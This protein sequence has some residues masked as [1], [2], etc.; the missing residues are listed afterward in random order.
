MII[1]FVRHGE[2]HRPAGTSH[3]GAK[4]IGLSDFGK[5]RVKSLAKKL[6]KLEIEGV[7]SSTLFRAVETATPLSSYC[8]VPLTYDNRL[9]EHTVSRNQTDRGQIREL[10]QKVRMDH[11]FVPPDGESF[12][13]TVSR[14]RAALKEIASVHGGKIVVVTH[15]EILQNF[16]LDEFFLS[17]APPI[18]EASYS[19]VEYQDGA[20]RLISLNNRP[21]SL[22]LLLEKVQRRLKTLIRPNSYTSVA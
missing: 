3:A 5:R 1:Y 17:E 12:A 2:Y 16:L 4:R 18:S 11:K 9:N 22:G 19:M 6:C 13:Q 15:R 10:R 14:F 20:F 8:K 7:V 21:F